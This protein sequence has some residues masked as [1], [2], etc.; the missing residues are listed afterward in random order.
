MRPCGPEGALGHA[1]G[2]DGKEGQGLV[3]A[4]QQLRTELTPKAPPQPENRD[5]QKKAGTPRT[6]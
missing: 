2:H 6:C 5:E 3:V 4:H 1:G